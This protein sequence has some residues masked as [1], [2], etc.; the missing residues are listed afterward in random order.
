MPCINPNSPEFKE[1]LKETGNPLLAEIIV[2][3]AISK[4]DITKLENPE[5]I[6]DLQ[7]TVEY[8]LLAE[9]DETLNLK[10]GKSYVF[11]DEKDAIRFSY[12][13]KTQK[14]FPREFKVTK[15][16]TKYEKDSKNPMVFNPY[17][18]YVDFQYVKS[19]KNKRSNLYDI[20]N[21]ETGE[22]VAS[23]VRVLTVS[24]DSKSEIAK[25]YG[26]EFTPTK[27]FSAGRSIAF[28]LYRQKP[29]KAKYVAQAKKYLYDAIKFLN[30]DEAA[31]RIN[32]D[33]IESFLNAFPE[34]MWDYINTTY[35]PENSTNV[36][37]SISLRNNIEFKLPK[38]GLL[39]EIEKITEMKLQGVTFKN[40]DR[41]GS[42]KKNLKTDWG[43]DVTI[44]YKKMTSKQLK[45]AISYY[46]KNKGYFKISSEE[47]NV[48]KF[49]EH[50]NIDHS[51]LRDLV[52]GDDAI[53][54]EHIMYN[55]TGDSD[56]IALSKWR[57]E[58]RTYDWQSYELFQ[59]PYKVFNEKVKDS[60]TEK[61]KDKK[62]SNGISHL[63][64]FFN[65]NF[66]WL[67]INFNNISGQYYKRNFDIKSDVGVDVKIA[68]RVS[69][70]E[71]KSYKAP[72][73][74]EDYLGEEEVFNRLAAILHEPFHALHALSYGSK[75]EVELRA[76]FDKLYNTGFGKKMMDE[77]FGEGYNQ[78]QQMSY[79]TLY[80]EFTAFSTQLMLYP[81]EW[82]RKTDLRSND[83]FEFVER[84]QSLQDKTYEEILKVQQKIGTTERV[85]TEEE[86]IKLNFLQKLYNYLVKALNKIIPLSKKF[87]STI[88]DSKLVEKTIIEDVFGETEERITKTLKLPEDIKKSKEAFLEAMDELK[89]AINTL[90]QIDSK[91]FSS[92]NARGFFSDTRPFTREQE[93][94]AQPEEETICRTP[95]LVSKNSIDIPFA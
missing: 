25:K 46:L 53:A 52:F 87:L 73:P 51:K 5:Q 49:A 39:Q 19:N 24:K 43:G 41:S 40:Y 69:P 57:E 77:V 56:T 54:L 7:D 18:E 62:L 21:L 12:L 32:L 37:A 20:I 15:K 6:K 45:I 16:I 48:K 50:N 95:S 47:E 3:E 82:I 29:S 9:K 1:A 2:S 74:N 4:I 35:S 42:I 8:R 65:G 76:A 71:I 67:N 13:L 85:I 86:Q 27:L 58:I 83:I 75:E 33:K 94:Q 84:I 17:N 70:I 91:A 79:E 36:N 92:E 64:Y 11:L 30:P 34:D 14:G 22:V 44:D 89:S 31:V 90:M 38:L 68:G 93:A 59:K 60:V 55:E 63:D 78:G 28:A 66:N 81:K 88:A 23:K 72:K 80:K 61:F 10:G 26:V